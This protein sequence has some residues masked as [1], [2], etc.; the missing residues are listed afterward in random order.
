MQQVYTLTGFR[1]R[2]PRRDFWAGLL[3]LLL[4]EAALLLLGFAGLMRPTGA[5]P[6]E[7]ATMWF[8]L[9]VWLWVTAALIVKRL[10]D[11]DKSAIWYPLFGLAPALCYHLGNVYSGNISNVLSPAQRLFWSLGGVLCLWALV[12]L[13]FMPGT[14]GPN[15][16]GPDPRDAA[17]APATV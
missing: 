14:K 11:R 6:I 10:H 5:T 17:K 15:R 4:I 12:E 9:A 13:G 8:A 2:I 1:G 7:E 16:Y 3:L